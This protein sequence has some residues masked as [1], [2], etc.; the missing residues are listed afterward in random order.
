[1]KK[2]SLSAVKP[3]S[4]EPPADAVGKPREVFLD[5]SLRKCR[6]YERSRLL[7]TNE[8]QGPA[9]IEERVSTTLLLEGYSLKVDP[10]GH[11]VISA[12]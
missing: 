10:Y 2:A 1:M 12:G 5:G 6:I 3:G 9:V 4:I 8:I 11:L 7:A